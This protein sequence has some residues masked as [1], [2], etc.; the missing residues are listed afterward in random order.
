[1]YIPPFH[2][3]SIF[4]FSILNYPLSIKKTS[5]FFDFSGSFRY[6][7]ADNRRKPY[8]QHT[9]HP[10]Q[11]SARI[12]K[13]KLLIMDK[14]EKLQAYLDAQV[15]A[16]ASA[17]EKAYIQGYKDAIDE[18]ARDYIK[19]VEDGV[20]YMDLGLPSGTLWAINNPR[21]VTYQESQ[22]LNIP[23]L[24]QVQELVSFIRWQIFQAGNWNCDWRFRILDV[25]G[26]TFTI[27]TSGYVNGSEM[28]LGDLYMWYRKELDSDCMAS[29]YH[30]AKENNSSNLSGIF[31]GYKAFAFFVK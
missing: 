9:G 19:V 10:L 7:C 22:R 12:K 20:E 16:F 5:S 21:L 30:L 23:T 29:V 15:E 2:V 6:L 28:T 1:M 24:E 18:Q 13:L 11:G 4:Q 26:R 31:P 17:I 25:E 14:S 8:E 27:N 3:L